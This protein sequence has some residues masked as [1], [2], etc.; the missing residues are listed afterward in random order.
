MS[1]ATQ[2][3]NQLLLLTRLIPP[4]PTHHERLLIIYHFTKDII[5]LSF[6]KVFVLS[7]HETDT[8]SFVSLD[9]SQI[10]E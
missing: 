7:N 2:W 5:I 3:S 4:L 10:Q 6:E 9:E 1:R 8:M